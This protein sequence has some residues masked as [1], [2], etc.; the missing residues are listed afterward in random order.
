MAGIDDV[1]VIQSSTPVREKLAGRFARDDS[2]HG[3]A[4]LVIRNRRADRV[5]KAPGRPLIRAIPRDRHDPPENYPQKP[6][7]AIYS[8]ASRLSQPR[9]AHS[10]LLMLTRLTYPAAAAP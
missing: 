3:N 9:E 4:D 1:D 8:P 6:E 5:L 10:C 2:N 7:P